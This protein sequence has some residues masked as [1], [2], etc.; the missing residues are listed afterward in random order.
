[1]FM[2]TPYSAVS[3]GSKDAYNLY[4]SQLCIQIECAFGML[5]HQ[6]AILC[7]AIPMQVLIRKTIALVIIT[8]QAA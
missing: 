3:G 1:M 6:W 4:H 2:A 8:V 5:T 7:S